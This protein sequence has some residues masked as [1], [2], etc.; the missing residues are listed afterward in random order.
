VVAQERVDGA[1]FGVFYYR[2]PGEPTGRIFA[3]TDKRLPTVTGDGRR[4]LEQLILADERAVCSARFFLRRH[5]ARLSWV[6]AAGE[7]VQLTPL[8]THS[9]GA[10]FLD[11]AQFLTP[12]LERAIDRLSQGYEEFWFGRYDVRAPSAEALMAGGPFTV[13]EVNGVSSE[14][15]S[16]YDPRHGLGHAYRTLFAQWRLAF[17]IGRRNVAAGARPTRVR[18]ILALLRRHRAATALH[19]DENGVRLQ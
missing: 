4:P 6:P 18:E 16:I 17:E 8:G 19:A 15:T 10:M 13:L 9:R 5:A 12:A 11:G 7:T 2:L 14:A 1:E 3:I